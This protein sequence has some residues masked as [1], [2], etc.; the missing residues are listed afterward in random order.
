MKVLVTGGAG[1]IGANFVLRVRETRPQWQL[2]VIDSLTYA[3][4]RASLAPVE[5]EIAFVEGDIADAAVRR[6]VC[7]PMREAVVHY[8]AESH[9]DNCAARPA[10]RS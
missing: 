8:A 2:T 5:G 9:N 3:G 6:L 4:N 7:S 10:A 1:F